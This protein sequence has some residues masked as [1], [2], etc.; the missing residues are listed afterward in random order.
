MQ[1]IDSIQSI[2][3]EIFDDPRL[4]IRP[5]TR[6]EDIPDWDSVA[7]VKI[8]LAIE[9]AFGMRFTTSEVAQLHSVG[10]FL[11]ALDPLNR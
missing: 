11:H 10:D 4:E 5:S 9:E 6:P 3:Q 1:P 7:Q 8:V 2:F